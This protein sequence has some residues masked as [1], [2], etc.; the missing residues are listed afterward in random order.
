MESINMESDK[1]IKVVED[2]CLSG[3]DTLEHTVSAIELGLPVSRSVGFD[4][5]E[6]EK[7]LDILKGVIKEYKKTA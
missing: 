2:L 1:I 4:K 3:K 6:Q 7:L 5:R